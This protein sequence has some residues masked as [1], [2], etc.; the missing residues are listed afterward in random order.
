MGAAAVIGRTISHY[1]ILRKLGSGGMGVVYEAED[2]NLGRHVAAKF[3][4]ENLYRDSIALERFEQE[5]R[6]T[7]LLNHPNICAIYEIEEDE[8]KPFLVMELLEGED[9]KKRMKGKPLDGLELLD[10][11]VQVGDAL[12]AAHT[13]GIIHRDIK[14]ANV[15]ITKRG[16]VRLLDFG[17]A[18]MS[19][20][21]LTESVSDATADEDDL[22]LTRTDVIPGTAVYMSPEQIRGEE[23]DTRSDIFSLG[24][25]LYEM[26][27]GQK[28]FAK[29]NSLLTLDAI[30]NQKP[31]SPLKLNPNLPQGL[32]K[33]LG[34]A[35][36][37]KREERY[38]KA[39]EL[40]DDLQR[41]RRESELH[42][43]LSDVKALPVSRTFSWWSPRHVYLQLA[44]AGTFA[45]MVLIGGAL[46]WKAH[47]GGAS[48]GAGRHSSIAVL[49]I[50]NLVGENAADPLR[51]L[52]A[53]EIATVLSKS[54][55]IEV[56]PVSATQKYSQW[57]LDVQR[58]GEELG[59]STILD[60]HYAREGSDLRVTVQAIDV[61]T[62]S[63]LWE[64]TVS[65]ATADAVR[66]KVGNEIQHSLL[67]LLIHNTESSSPTG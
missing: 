18:K 45:I 66:E 20:K 19:R 59:V 46:Y 3:L 12:D 38:Q 28:P 53:D 60:G 33:V 31:V 7:S 17:L 15:F 5:A 22:T 67:P 37:K 39:Y 26:A 52:L 64:S 16:Q 54:R 24:V 47:G 8:G 23:L 40:R 65:G 34:K 51:V 11:G 61:K 35:L 9:L 30:L 36:A 44:L 48:A 6:A 4:P 62:N 57:N 58:A 29:K 56:R 2:I 14:P 32:E 41:L 13:E 63:V 43:T 55:A 42:P 50:D 27:T 21:P 10:I 25:V 1:K 49:P